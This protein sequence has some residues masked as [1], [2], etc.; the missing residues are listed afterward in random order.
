MAD[1]ASAYVGCCFEGEGAPSYWPFV[2]ILRSLIDETDDK[3]LAETLRAGDADLLPL[4][5]DLAER[6]PK[7]SESEA[8]EGEQARFR[9]FDSLAGFL[10]RSARLRPLVLVLEDLHWADRDSMPLIS[11]LAGALRDSAVFIVGTYRDLDVR[12]EH[13]L[14]T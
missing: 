9:F 10:R 14:G 1:R 12:R 11:F 13:P 5:P 8:L 7:I 6:L 2:Q 4:I 3:Q